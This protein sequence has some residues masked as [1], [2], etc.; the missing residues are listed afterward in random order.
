[1]MRLKILLPHRIFLDQEIDKLVAEGVNGFFCIKPK[2]IDFISALAPGLFMLENHDGSEEFFGL[3]EGILIKQGSEVFV[4]T[5]AA[6]R[7]PSLEKLK[8]SVIKEFRKSNEQEKRFRSII[9]KLEADTLRR[10]V[11][12]GGKEND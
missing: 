12:L 10:F 9:A 5:Q 2:H 6:V 7:G 8:H 11:E 1:M 4:S 3:N